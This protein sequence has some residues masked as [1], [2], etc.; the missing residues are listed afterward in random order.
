MKR[1]TDRL[2]DEIIKAIY[3]ENIDLITDWQDTTNIDY[4]DSDGRTMLFHAILVG[5]KSIVLVL[6]ENGA[7][8]NLKDHKGWYPLHYAAQNYRVEI[9]N[10]LLEKG[11]DIEAKDAYGNTPLWRSVFASQGRG[12]MIAM[13]LSKGAN[14]NNAND[15]GVSPL[16]LAANIANYN[17]QQFFE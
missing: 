14:P 1:K 17:I 10:L 9:A 15:S 11:A 3:V 5:S 6:L 2:P 4:T 12:E 7:T 13:F 16:A 8:V